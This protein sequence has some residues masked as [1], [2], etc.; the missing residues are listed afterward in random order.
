LQV[1]EGGEVV[2]NWEQAIDGRAELVLLHRADQGFEIEAAPGGRDAQGDGVPDRFEDVEARLLA[3][4][5]A[6]KWTNPPCRVA[7]MERWSESA[8]TISTTTSAPIR[9]VRSMTRPGQVFER[10]TMT[11]AAPSARSPASCSSRRVTA[12]TRAPAVRAN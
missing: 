7:A 8:P 10:S 2:C 4:G 1:L 11:A 3:R 5:V 12:M 6:I 9:S